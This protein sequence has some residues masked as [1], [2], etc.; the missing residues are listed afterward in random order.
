MALTLFKKFC[1]YVND[2][3]FS[4][5][6]VGDTLAFIVDQAFIDDFC[7]VA[8]VTEE[9]LLKEIRRGLESINIHS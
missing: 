8:G 7:K 1:E 6:N 4:K 2:T 9:E 3:I 5:E